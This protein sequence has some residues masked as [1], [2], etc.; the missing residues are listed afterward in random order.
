M[1]FF[2]I[3]TRKDCCLSNFVKLMLNET[4]I[5]NKYLLIFFNFDF[6]FYEFRQF[7]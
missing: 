4:S 2:I 6:D 1:Y 5:T 7:I 3:V